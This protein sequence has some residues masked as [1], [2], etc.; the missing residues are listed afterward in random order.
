MKLLRILLLSV[1]GLILLLLIIAFAIFMYV[2]SLAKQGIE[3]GGTYALGVTTRVQNVDIGLIRGRVEI[4]GLQVANPTGYTAPHFMRMENGRTE[5]ALRTLRQDVIRIPQLRLS[6]LELVLERKPGEKANYQV[7]LDNLEKLK[8]PQK[9]EPSPEKPEGKKV[10]VDELIL[11]NITVHV[12]MMRGEGAIGQAVGQLARVTVPIEEIRLTEV[13]QTGSGV[14]GSGVTLG[15]LAGIV[16]Q[17]VLAAAVEKGG[18]ILPADLLGDV[19]ARLSALGDLEEVR[20][21]ISGQIS[22]IG[23]ALENI[24]SPEDVQDVLKKGTE[25]LDKLKDL[26]PKR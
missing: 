10:I 5:I 23:E 19:R 8:G 14:A 22:E 4:E 11:R 2:D 7:I 26:I 25:G 12:D 3:R 1:G 16:V 6:D 17:A 24:K 13:G 21:Q 15:E 20:V 9:P 18:D